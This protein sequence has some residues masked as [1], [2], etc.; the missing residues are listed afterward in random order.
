M[1]RILMNHQDAKTTQIYAHH[2]PG[3]LAEAD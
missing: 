1:I 3:Q 2:S